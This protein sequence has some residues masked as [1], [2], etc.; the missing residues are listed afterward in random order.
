MTRSVPLSMLYLRQGVQ[1]QHRTVHRLQR[2]AA[3]EVHWTVTGPVQC[4]DSTYDYSMPLAKL[5]SD[6]CPFVQQQH[7]AFETYSS[8]LRTRH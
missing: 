6:P 8:P 3:Q 7:G 1:R 2:L 5:W 4:D